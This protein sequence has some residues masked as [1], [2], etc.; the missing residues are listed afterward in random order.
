M[1]GT[2]RAVG[3]DRKRIPYRAL[4]VLAACLVAACSVQTAPRAVPPPAPARQAPPPAQR[5]AGAIYAAGSGLELFSD[6]KARRVG[7]LLTIQLVESTSAAKS[8]KTTARKGQETEMAPPLI[9][10]R[11]PTLDGAPL[12]TSLSAN[13]DFSGEGDSSQSNRLFGHLTVTVVDR[14]PNGNLVV[15]GEKRLML[16]QGEETV[17][18]SGIVRPADVS[19]NNIVPSYKVADA[20]IT[21]GGRGFIAESNRMGWLA[22]FF[23]SGWAPY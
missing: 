21:Y 13:R 22:R 17:R 3:R 5:T 23:N 10:G 8:A 1:N 11:T 19:T 4:P 14:L 2:S 20:R 7:D 16:N 18:I 12:G 6:V 9:L 15:E